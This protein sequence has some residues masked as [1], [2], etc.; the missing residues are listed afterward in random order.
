VLPKK[1][2][3]EDREGGKAGEERRI[4]RK[5]RV[6]GKR[7]GK[8]RVKRRRRTGGHAWKTTSRHRFWKRLRKF[9]R[10]GGG[11]RRRSRRRERHLRREWLKGR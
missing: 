1:A 10:V 7:K 2:L 8:E 11:G 5:R 9:R 3:L 4:R 6:S